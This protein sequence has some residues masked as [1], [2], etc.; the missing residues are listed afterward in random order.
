MKIYNAKVGTTAYFKNRTWSGYKVLFFQRE[1]IDC[2]YARFMDSTNLNV[3]T[4]PDKGYITNGTMLTCINRPSAE[5]GRSVWMI[6]DPKS[7]HFGKLTIFN[8]EWYNLNTDS[9][10]V[11]RGFP[12]P[13]HYNLVKHVQKK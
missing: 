2:T 9:N 4:H 12:S 1:E 6:T 3:Y 8:G 11:R 13:T 5:S 10:G 7:K